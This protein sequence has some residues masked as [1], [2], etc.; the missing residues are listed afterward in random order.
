MSIPKL[1]LVMRAPRAS[2]LTLLA[3][4][5]LLVLINPSWLLTAPGNIDP[6]IYFG[7]FGNFPDYLRV[8]GDT[9]YAS[10]LAWIV[11]GTLVHEMMPP[12]AARYVLHV[13]VFYVAL[14]AIHFTLRRTAGPR[15]ALFA[16]ILIGCDTYF[17]RAVGWD[18]VDGAGIATTPSRWRA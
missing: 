9:Y 3:L 8:F 1:E 15:A 12:L 4:P 18:Y 14:F 6:W 7:F 10:R 13:G 16:S 11:P 17:L 2:T 5:W